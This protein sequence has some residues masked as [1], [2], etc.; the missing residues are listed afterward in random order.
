MRRPWYGDDEII[1]RWWPRAVDLWRVALAARDAAA[2]PGLDRS[3]L[4]L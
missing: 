4:V 1:D 2:T 3:E